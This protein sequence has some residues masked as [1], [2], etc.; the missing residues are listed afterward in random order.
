MAVG[1]IWLPTTYLLFKNKMSIDSYQIPQ[2]LTPD[3]LA[4]FLKVSKA[5][6]YRLIKKRKITFHKVGRSLRFDRN[7]VMSYLQKNRVESIGL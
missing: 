2:M 4:D 7:D 1:D 5:G 3:E 6:V